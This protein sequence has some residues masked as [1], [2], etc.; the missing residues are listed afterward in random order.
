MVY[1]QGAKMSKSLGNLV[2]VSDLL[3]AYTPDALRLY[4]S[5]HRY[6][7]A[8]SHDQ[9]ALQRA[10]DRA[11]RWEAA[12]AVEGGAAIS[13]AVER[14]RSEFRV[15]MEDD[16]DTTRAASALDHLAGEIIPA[17]QGGDPASQRTLRELAGLLGLRLGLQGS[18]P[19]VAD[20]WEVHKARFWAEGAA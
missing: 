18:E 7:E 3:Q 15:A 9:M 4:L 6:R 17:P 14:C 10:A 11:Q 19:R 8:W 12:A 13:P 2:M 5:G 20:G 16:L 1:Y